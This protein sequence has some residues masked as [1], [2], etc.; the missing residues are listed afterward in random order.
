MNEKQLIERIKH[1]DAFTQAIFDTLSSEQKGQATKLYRTYLQNGVPAN[2]SQN[3][4]PESGRDKDSLILLG[5]L[6][7]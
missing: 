3:Q 6:D 7:E 4:S 1:L 2:S 5:Y